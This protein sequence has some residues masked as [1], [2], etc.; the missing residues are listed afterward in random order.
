MGSLP[1]SREELI[2]ES[3]CAKWG[4]GR[5]EALEAVWDWVLAGAAPRRLP[6]D[7]N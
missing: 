3:R 5:W 6:S 1:W 2:A 4:C 7:L